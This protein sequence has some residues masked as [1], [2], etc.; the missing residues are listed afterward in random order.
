MQV[1][2][3]C[4]WLQVADEQLRMETRQ[5]DWGRESNDTKGPDKA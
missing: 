3:L 1:R 4:I 5:A 2:S